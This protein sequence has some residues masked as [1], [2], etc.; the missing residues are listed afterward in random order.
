[1]TGSWNNK[2]LRGALASFLIALHFVLLCA[3]SRVKSPTIDE[4][5]YVA[6]GYYYVRT[7][8][9]RL[10]RTH[11]PLIRLLSGIPLQFLS[12]HAPSPQLEKWDTP[13]S[14]ELG[15]YLGKEM[16]L[17]S[18]NDVKKILFAARLPI[19]LLS[20]ALGFLLYVWGTQLYGAAGGLTV[21]FLYVLC[22]NMLAHAQLATLD[23][24]ISFFMALALYAMARYAQSP[25]RIHLAFCGIAVGAALA[26][27]VTAL[28]LLPIFLAA[29]AW[30]LYTP[31]RSMRSFPWGRFAMQSGVLLGCSLVVLLLLY[32]YPFKPFY[33]W[34]TLQNVFQKSFSGGRGGEDIPGMPHRNYAFYL[35]G[36]YS[37]EGWPYYYLVAAAVKTPLAIFAT[38]VLYL[39]IG[40]RRWRGLPD[41]LMVGAIALIHLMAAFNRVNIGLRHVLPFYPLLYL[42]MGRVAELG[43]RRYWR[44]T[45]LILGLGYA[46]TCAW[47]YPD[48]LSYFNEAAG[49]PSQ[50]YKYLDDSN[51]DWGQDL[52]RLAAVQR[53]YPQEPFYIAQDYIFD[54]AAYGFSAKPFHQ[55]Q[56]PSPPQGIVAV[57]KQWAIRHRIQKRSPYYFDWLEKYRPVGEVGRSI[58]IFKFDRAPDSK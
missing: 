5:T 25:G 10:D 20:C 39:S 43:S 55:E 31:E 49:G 35:M 9:F 47:I 37:T 46:L 54:P 23:L 40:P 56:I 42:Y 53:Q 18:G 41:F 28:L 26:A 52:G 3:S 38:L 16:L 58:W 57:S 13:A 14:Y 7:G 2:W 51:L 50:G 44:S 17:Q 19:M 45:L 4:Y 24:G 27:K 36:N 15:Y 30:I 6:S 21:L 8:D 32:G 1:M 29:L 34:D 11:P 12:I 33:Y 22:P 48:F